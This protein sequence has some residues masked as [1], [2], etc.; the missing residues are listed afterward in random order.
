MPQLSFPGVYIEEV[1]S[2]VRTITAVPTSIGAFVDFFAEGPMDTAV[3]IQ[4]MTDFGR[5]FGGLDA[6]SPAS[7]A[8]A[9]FFLNGGPECYVVRVTNAT[10]PAQT[11]SATVDDEAVASDILKFSAANA[12]AWGDR[13][14]VDI[15]QET[16][17]SAGHFNVYVRRYAANGTAVLAEETYLNLSVE[18]TDPNYVERNINNQSVLVT[19]KHT[20]TGA[21]PEPLPASTGTK[22]ADI[23]ALT[24]AQLDALS[25]GV[26]DVQIGATTKTATLDTWAPNAVTTLSQLRARV[27]RAVRHADSLDPAFAGASVSLI[28]GAQLVVHS[29]KQAT[30]YLPEQTVAISQNG[31][32]PTAAS[33]GFA[34]GTAIENVQEY[35]LGSTAGPVAA[36]VAANQGGD[37]AAPGA[38]DIIGSQAVDPPTGM[39]AL[40]KADLFNILCLPR[41][42]EDDLSDPE[43]TAIVSNA[44]KY[45]DDRR[46]FMI[47]DIPSAIDTIQ[48]MKDW[49]DAHANFRNNNAATYFPRLVIPDPLDGFRPKNVA[50]SG[51]VAGIYART[52]AE[53]GVWKAPAGIDAGLEG[54][55]ELAFKMT[56]KQN[57]TLNVLG[58]NCLR[59]FPI[60]GKVVWGARTLQGADAIGSEWKYIP[61][62]RFA[63]NL[64]ESLF[65]GTKWVVFEPNDEPLWANIRLN[66]NAFMNSL[67]RQGAFQG[68]DPKQAYFVKVDKETTTED[69]R[70]KGIINILVGFAPLKPAEFV[71]IR[72]Q[73]IKGDL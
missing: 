43:M 15:D 18:K 51:T 67:F 42:A 24:Q 27:E 34:G 66:I 62:R 28:G 14:R 19:V 70:N 50:A 33:L 26:F 71:V 56:D 39:F 54:V 35:P 13:V 3:L 65:R 16:S 12:G 5:V 44:L 31:A 22:G 60:N 58:I 61:I 38:A 55:T 29:G 48:E 1:P 72:I 11:A 25:A 41:A 53:R 4:G 59:V 37:G 68:T 46:A 69:D 32:D 7:Y 52:D 9:Q 40:D 8:I 30:T 47:I 10:T 20:P 6:R 23:S 63:L 36:W 45:C 2:G 17:D 64:E 57:G 21:V 49:M 73:Q